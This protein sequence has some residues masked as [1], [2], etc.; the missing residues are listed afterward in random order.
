MGRHP[1]LIKF[2][3]FSKTLPGSLSYNYGPCSIINTNT[4]TSFQTN[5]FTHPS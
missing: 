2:P 5:M 4:N 3:D 1:T